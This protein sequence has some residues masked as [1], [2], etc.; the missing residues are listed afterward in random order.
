MRASIVWLL[1]ALVPGCGDDSTKG[2]DGA[3]T[4]EVDEVGDDAEVVPDATPED[5]G[6]DTEVI[7]PVVEHE[8]GSHLWVVHPL[9]GGADDGDNLQRALDEATDL[10][11]AEDAAQCHIVRLPS[12][13]CFPHPTDDALGVDLVLE[14]LTLEAVPSE[15]LEGAP[16]PAI[17]WGLPWWNRNILSFGYPDGS[18]ISM[19]GTC[20]RRTPTSG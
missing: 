11:S 3:E 12:L 8:P 9:G 14:D 6:D 20:A 10:P 13:L 5:T 19:P 18:P 2:S 4:R 17:F 1:L 15:G 7:E 16:D